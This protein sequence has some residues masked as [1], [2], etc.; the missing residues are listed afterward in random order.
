M[1]LVSVHKFSFHVWPFAFM[2]QVT[3]IKK[4]LFQASVLSSSF[5]RALLGL[6]R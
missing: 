3:R 5:A 6:I 1:S 4:V 2:L